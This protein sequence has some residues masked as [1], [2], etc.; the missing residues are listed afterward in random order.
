MMSGSVSSPFAVFF[1]ILIM[2]TSRPRG[3][4]WRSRVEINRVQRGR[5]ASAERHR[6]GG[7]K[8]PPA[9]S[10]AAHRWPCVESIQWRPSLR[11]GAFAGRGVHSN[12]AYMPHVPETNTSPRARQD[13]GAGMCAVER[14]RTTQPERD[15]SRGWRRSVSVDDQDRA[16]EDHP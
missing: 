4:W 13:A 5:E 8:K 11:P 7:A 16:K 3:L 10:A 9:T 12:S 15:L 6:A 1:R 2:R 14:L